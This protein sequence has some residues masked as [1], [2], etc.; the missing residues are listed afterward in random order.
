MTTRLIFCEGPDDLNALRA[1]AQV[2]RWAQP[3]RAAGAGAGLEREM[4]LRAGDAL[5]K[6]GVPSKAR[7]AAGEG[8]SAL[9]RS[10]ADNLGALRMQ[11]DAADE[12]SVSLVAAVYDPDDQSAADFHTELRQ[13]IRDHA[14]AWTL[15]E[16]GT[17]GVWRAR[18]EAG[19]EVYVR[20]VHWRAPGSILDGLPD[21]SNLERL[22]CAVVAKAHPEEKEHVARWLTEIGEVRQ[23]ANRK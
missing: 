2:L 8:K 4:V 12:S 23:K 1:V 21:H 9:A 14:P 17:P 13:A 5:I 7:G 22:L 16:L 19:E 18:R 15:A 11:V 10:V 6:V 3:V 20:A